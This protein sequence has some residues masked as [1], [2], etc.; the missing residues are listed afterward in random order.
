VLPFCLSHTE[1]L[2]VTLT[3]SD[4]LCCALFIP[5]WHYS[6]PLSPL[7]ITY[8]SSYKSCLLCCLSIPDSCPYASYALCHRICSFSFNLL[9]PCF[10]P[11]SFGPHA[12]IFLYSWLCTPFYLCFCPF[13]W[14]STL[15]RLSSLITQP[16]YTAY[17]SLTKHLVICAYRATAPPV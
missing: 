17:Q 9:I 8:Q 7:S 1:S 13:P 10:P 3:H 12:M 11:L 16:D 2:W 15:F 4:S 14:F 5:S 6:S